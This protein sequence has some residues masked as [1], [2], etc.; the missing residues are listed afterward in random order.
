MTA[1]I[2]ALR[3]LVPC[4]NELGEGA[5]WD[6][7]AGAFYWVDIIGGILHRHHLFTGENE[8]WSF[9]ERI[10]SFALR[11]SGGLLCAMESGLA[12]FDPDTGDF[13]FFARPEIHIPGNRFND[14]RCDRFGRFFVG[15]MDD[16]AEKR[17]GTLYRVDPDFTVHALVDGICIS[18]SVAFSP[19]G[20]HMYLADTVD[21]EIRRYDLDE[22]TGAVS[23]RMRFASTAGTGGGHPDGST[24]D[25]EGYLWNAEWD[26]WRITRYAP[27]GT[28]DRVLE[29]PV[30]RPTC[31]AFGGPNLSTLFVTSARTGLSDDELEGQP[32][33]GSIIAVEVGIKGLPEP[34]FAG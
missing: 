13:E 2:G 10:C 30:Q 9:D 20:R 22:R 7:E 29:L 3:Q 18:N 25:A 6:D 17:S 16:E 33:A 12:L 23:G 27:D 28:R 1:T 24:V 31:C 34:K 15:T 21:D 14:G 8:S 11:R 4:A 26:G 19:D 5:V 32:L